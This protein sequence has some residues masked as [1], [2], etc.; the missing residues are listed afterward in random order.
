M[1][2]LH[3]RDRRGPAPSTFIGYASV[4]PAYRGPAPRSANWSGPCCELGLHGLKLYPMYQDWSPA[5]P[6]IA[7][8]VFEKA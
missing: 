6:V 7:F 1:Q 5:D 4:N 8:P 2:R 3:R